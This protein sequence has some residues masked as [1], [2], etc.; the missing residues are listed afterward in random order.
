MI[1]E[2]SM[3]S[4]KGDA[5]DSYYEEQEKFAEELEK[6][7]PDLMDIFDDPEIFK[8]VEQK[9]KYTGKSRKDLYDEACNRFDADKVAVFFKQFKQFQEKKYK[10]ERIGYKKGDFIGQEYEVVE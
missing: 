1:M 8:W 5:E 9:D 6:K 7:V 3:P 4:N 2:A 10:P